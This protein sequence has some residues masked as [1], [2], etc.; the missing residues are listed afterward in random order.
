MPRTTVSGLVYAIAAIVTLILVAACF[1]HR[2]RL[3][4]RS[5]CHRSVDSWL[6]TASSVRYGNLAA[7]TSA[8]PSNGQ[9]RP[10][11]SPIALPADRDADEAHNL[12][13]SS[14]PPSN[15]LELLQQ[16][17]EQATRRRTHRRTEPLW[18]VTCE[19]HRWISRT[20]AD[21]ISQGDH[22]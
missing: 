13:S 2:H 7:T 14:P 1:I 21:L 22:H 18:T 5:Q 12:R 4:I 3:A 10:M 19:S 17:A 6:A 11:P 20:H 16:C 15:E 9:Q 8:P